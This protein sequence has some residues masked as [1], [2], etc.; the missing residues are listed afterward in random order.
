MRYPSF[1]DEAP[2]LTVYEPLGAF[3]GASED[4]LVE[5]CYLDAVKL[6]GHSCPPW[7]API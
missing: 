6:T 3:L 1:F 5:Y 4:G 2:R 7:L